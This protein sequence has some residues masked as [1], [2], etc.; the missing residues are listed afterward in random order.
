MCV[1]ICQQ[2]HIE[3]LR[4]VVLRL[5]FIEF[6]RSAGFLT[7]SSTVANNFR[8]L[9]ETVSRGIYLL[10]LSVISIGCVVKGSR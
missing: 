7:F 5:R 1:N 2:R 4:F 8:K 6:Y 9:V 10:V 3:L